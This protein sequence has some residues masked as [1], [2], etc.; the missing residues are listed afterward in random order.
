MKNNHLIMDVMSSIGVILVLSACS[1][2]STNGLEEQTPVPEMTATTLPAA[3]EENIEPEVGGSAEVK[4]ASIEV[5][6]EEGGAVTETI[7]LEGGSF[8]TMDSKGTEYTLT[9]PEGALFSEAEITMIPIASAEGEYIGDTFL[10]G[11]ALYPE[12]LHFLGLVTIEIRGDVIEEG[13]IGFSAQ[14]G[15]Q[16]FH[17][18][19]SQFASGSVTITTTHFSEF[20]VSQQ[21]IT[22]LAE[23]MLPVAMEQALAIGDDRQAMIALEHMINELL[24]AG[25]IENFE[26]WEPW[27]ADV[28]GLILR[29]EEVVEERGWNENTPGLTDTLNAMQGL[30]DQW[31]QQSDGV[32]QGLAAKCVQGEIEM[33]PRMNLIVKIGNWMHFHLSLDRAE[34]LSDWSDEMVSCVSFEITWQANVV[35]TGGDFSSDISVGSDFSSAALMPGVIKERTALEVEYIEG[36]FAD[37]CVSKPGV[38][39]LGVFFALEGS[40]E[41]YS[42]EVYIDNITLYVSI[43]DQIYIDCAPAGYEITAEAQKPFHGGALE[44]LNEHRLGESGSWEFEVEYDPGG[45]IIAQFEEGPES[46][47]WSEGKYE[48]WQLLTL[49]Q[50][51]TAE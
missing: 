43:V 27:T 10:A 37:I 16:D 49:Y 20:G 23:M 41:F 11:V 28:I 22:E 5:T 31:F 40:T 42:A 30:I 3:T 48:L 39:E 17:L 14:A 51:T 1:L 24:V 25:H 46:L 6:L 9:I 50:G 4:P 45:G 8:K 44:V 2:F 29:F 12:N 7:G 35:T 38:V 26:Q 21:E 15:G 32:M 33:A 19:P 34:V 47:S 18:T 36:T 13:V